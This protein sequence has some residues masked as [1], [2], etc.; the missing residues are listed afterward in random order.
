MAYKLKVC[1]CLNWGNLALGGIEVLIFSL[2]HWMWGS[3]PTQND[4]QETLERQQTLVL[5][6]WLT[7]QSLPLK[8]NSLLNFSKVPQNQVFGNY[9]W[10]FKWKWKITCR[11]SSKLHFCYFNR[12]VLSFL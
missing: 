5:W 12:L 6:V 1:N 7:D 10:F 3:G 11:V 4:S 9:S 2:P 8:D